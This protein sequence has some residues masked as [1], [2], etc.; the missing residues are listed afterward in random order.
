L[1]YKIKFNQE[2]IIIVAKLARNNLFIS[3][4]QANDYKFHL[5]TKKLVE[6]VCNK[7]PNSK[8]ILKLYP[9]A[10]Y[11]D[12]YEFEDLMNFKNLK[13]FKNTEFRW[14]KLIANKI[15]TNST[16][17]TLGQVLQNASNNYFLSFKSN[18]DYF[19]HMFDEENHLK[20]LRRLKILNK[21]KILSKRDFNVLLNEI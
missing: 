2:V 15:I 6:I 20:L 14:L 1:I 16:E 7:F 13:I 8:V 9:G 10:R 19:S 4:Y 11:I 21:D 3:P 12:E 17:S 18:P 5:T